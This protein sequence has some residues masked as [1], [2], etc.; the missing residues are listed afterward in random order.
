MIHL[1]KSP[2]VCSAPLVS[3]NFSTHVPVDD[4]LSGLSPEQIQLRETVRNFVE[5]E[6]GPFAD[7]IDANN[8]FAD[9]RGFWKKL[10]SIGLLGITAPG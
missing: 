7:E 5:K 2:A 9:L 8:D 10:G 3:R 6:L 1:L 4:V